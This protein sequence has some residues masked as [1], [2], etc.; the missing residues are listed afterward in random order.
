MMTGRTKHATL[1]VGVA[2]ALTLSACGGGSSD[3]GTSTDD[4]VLSVASLMEPTSWDPAQANEGHLVPFYQAVYD[5]LIREEPDGTLVPMLATDWEWSDDEMELTLTLRDD[6]TFSDG[7]SFDSAA[8]KA[9]IEHFQEANGPMGTVLDAIETVETPDATTAVLVLSEPDPGIP[10][11]L[12]G[13]AGYMGSP[14]A[15][16][17]SDI[18]T[19]PVGSGPYTLN[20]EETVTGSTISFERKDDYWGEELPYETVEYE[21]M[22][23]GTARLNALQS[24]QVDAA[25]FNRTSDALDAQEAGLNHEPYSINWA[26][27]LLFDREGEINPALA[28]VRVREALATSIDTEAILDSVAQGMGEL[29]DQTF[30]PDTTGFAEEFEDA[31]EYDPEHAEQLLAEAGEEDLTL[32][33]PTTTTFDSAIYDSI[34]Q[35]WEDIGITVERH[36]WGPSEAIPSMLRGDFAVSYM[37]LAQ[38]TSWQHIQFL[39]AP[40]GPW[41]PLGTQTDELDALIEQAQYGTDEERA[42]AAQEINEYVIDEVWFVPFYRLEQSFYYDDSVDVQNQDGQAVPSIYN[43]APAEG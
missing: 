6:V 28:D 1:A 29:T 5:T 15:L 18:E 2:A 24:G 25:V 8:V 43:Y 37:S 7:T 4:E 13:A 9:N 42:E 38:R 12:S 19:Q 23:D 31:Y 41:N 10:E 39:I 40:D 34:F 14:E 17:S 30:G 27:L 26:G 33:V 20:T 3:G 22:T 32:T 21:I 11:W 36:E 16:E 35:S